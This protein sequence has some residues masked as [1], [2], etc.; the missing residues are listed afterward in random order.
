MQQQE[1]PSR[2]VI[3]A[4][5]AIHIVAHDIDGL[6]IFGGE[7]AEGKMNRRRKT[8]AFIGSEGDD[9]VPERPQH[10]DD[11]AALVD[12]VGGSD[13]RIRIEPGHGG[14]Y[15]FYLRLD[16]DDDLILF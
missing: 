1:Q 11:L 2:H 3:A 13:D 9:A 16:A 8:V 14:E 4:L 6:V 10:R 5:V 7:D 12:G 15:F